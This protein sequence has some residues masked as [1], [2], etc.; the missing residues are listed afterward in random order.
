MKKR[1]GRKIIKARWEILNGEWVVVER[2]GIR[3]VLEML[4]ETLQ[5]NGIPWNVEL[6]SSKSSGLASYG[7]GA[8]SPNVGGI[9]DD[10]FGLTVPEKFESFALDILEDLKQQR[11]L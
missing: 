10:S 6:I 8:V 4:G 5:R 9:F 2:G 3:S 7:L 11:I 1:L